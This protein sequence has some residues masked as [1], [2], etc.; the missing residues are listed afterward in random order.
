MV[1]GS[2]QLSEQFQR[3]GKDSFDAALRSYSEAHKGFQT[4]ATTITDY[5]KKSFEDATCAFEQLVSAQSIEQA[6]EIQSQYAQKAFDTYVAEMSKLTDIYVSTARD[7]YKPVEQAFA[8]KG[9]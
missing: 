4:I 7:A 3:L 2:Q 8:N 1:E 6:V 5:S 9:A